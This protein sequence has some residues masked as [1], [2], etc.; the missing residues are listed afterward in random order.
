MKSL[1]APAVL[2][3]VLACSTATAQDVLLPTMPLS[4][5]PVVRTL[6]PTDSVAARYPY[7]YGSTAGP[8]RVYV[9]YGQIDHFPFRG[10][11]YGYPYDR[12]TFSTLG[13]G[14]LA[15]ARY[16]YPPLR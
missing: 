1:I 10:Q 15:P 12:F 3:V 4:P 14:N 2:A 16:F 9:P 13:G 8:A 11:P 7:S 6:G 5:T